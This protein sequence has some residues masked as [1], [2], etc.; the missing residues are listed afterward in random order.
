MELPHDNEGLRDLIFRHSARFATAITEAEEARRRQQAVQERIAVIDDG[1]TDLTRQA[2]RLAELGQ[3]PVAVEAQDLV[4]AL[5]H[6]RAR[7]I[8]QLNDNL[9]ASTADSAPVPTE[10]SGS[11][12]PVAEA[13]AE[14]APAPAQSSDHSVKSAPETTIDL[15]VVEPAVKPV[16]PPVSIHLPAGLS[17]DGFNRTEVEAGVVVQLQRHELPKEVDFLIKQ[18]DQLRSASAMDTRELHLRAQ[19]LVYQG[20]ALQSKHPD[21]AI[22]STPLGREIKTFFG[23][24]TR[25]AKDRLNE[26]GLYLEGLK[27]SDTGDWDRLART[28]ADSLQAMLLARQS[29][30]EREIAQQETQRRQRQVEEA[31]RKVCIELELEIMEHCM[32]VNHDAAWADELR[33]LATEALSYCGREYVKLAELLQP[34]ADLFESGKQYRPLRK[35][36]GK[37]SPAD[38]AST[39]DRMP[40]VQPGGET[41]SAATARSMPAET[42]R[43]RG[44]FT[45]KRAAMVGGSCRE[46]R[47]KQLQAFF[48]LAELDWIENERTETANGAVMTQ[49][50]KNGRYDCVFLLTRFCSHEIQNHLKPACKAAGV[51][52]ASVERGYGI[53]A[54]CAALDACGQYAKGPA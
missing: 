54:F 9:P 19:A 44:H 52:F 20:R 3:E 34:H 7:L 40:A 12:A 39:S 51:P 31:N 53:N 16:V 10:T 38:L 49:R 36:W 23:R 32:E 14:S 45:G 6:E 46:Y 42:E 37:K 17:L 24:M 41:A 2:A 27:A 47:R 35:Q 28:S 15:R 13:P 30:R 50:I 48:G 8:Q 29:Q 26:S 21:L 22:E 18:A 11:R 33:E 4:Q 1:L 5:K 25:I 43:W